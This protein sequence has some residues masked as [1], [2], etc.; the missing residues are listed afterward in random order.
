MQIISKTQKHLLWSASKSKS[1]NIHKN[2]PISLAVARKRTILI[3]RFSFK[4]NK[5]FFVK[6]LKIKT[7]YIKLMKLYINKPQ[8]GLVVQF[9]AINPRFGNNE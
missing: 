2:N 5:D 9:N 7:N 4:N 3:I 8:E 1:T 6:Y